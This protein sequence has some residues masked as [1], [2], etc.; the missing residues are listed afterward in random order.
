VA[1][2]EPGTW[3]AER[4]QAN[5]CIKMAAFELVKGGGPVADAGRLAVARCSRL[6]DA[7]T[8]ALK[9]AGPVYPYQRRLIADDFAHL[10]LITAVRARSIGCG[11][12]QGQPET[13]LETP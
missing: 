10:G 3:A 12:P 4:E 11:R 8:A 9:R 1:Q 7:F 6:E 13:L 2:Y 5:F